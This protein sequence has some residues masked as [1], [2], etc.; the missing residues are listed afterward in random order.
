MYFQGA[1]TLV[2]VRVGSEFAAPEVRAVEQQ[3]ISTTPTS[4]APGPALPALSRCYNI[5]ICYPKWEKVLR[6]S[7]R[8]AKV[9]LIFATSVW[10]LTTLWWA[11]QWP[12]LIRWT[13]AVKIISTNYTFFSEHQPQWAG[14]VPDCPVHRLQWRSAH[15]RPLRH[16]HRLPHDPQRGRKWEISWRCDSISRM[17][18]PFQTLCCC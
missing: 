15:T 3:Q 16:Q 17:V 4:P 11:L 8:F 2:A 1:L 5:S 13:L 7:F 18:S 14:P 6:D 9:A 10:I 12:Q